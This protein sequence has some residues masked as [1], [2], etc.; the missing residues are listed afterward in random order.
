[1]SATYERKSR[2]GLRAK[3]N[4]LPKKP[5]IYFI[6]N[7]DNAV[8]YIGKARSLRERV[9]S[10]LAPT[11]DPKVHSI[12]T[13][14]SDID[15]LLTDS[16][17]EASFLENNFIQQY[18]PKFNIKLKDDKAFPFLKVTC[19]E[20]FPGIYLT[21]RVEPDGAKYFGPFAPA[22]Q[23]RKNIQL[24]NKYFGVRH[25]LEA[26]P[27]KRKRPCLE[28]DLKFCSAP[29]VG[30]ISKQ[31]YRSQVDSALLFLEGKTEELLGVLKGKMREAAEQQEYERAALLRDLILSIEQLKEKPKLIS[32]KKEDKDIFGFSAE[33][34][35]AY[36]SL[37]RMREGKVIESEII[38]AEM[39]KG[40]PAA[41][42][43]AS[44][45]QE[46]YSGRKDMPDQIILPFH[47]EN[48]E[49]IVKFLSR[50]KSKKIKLLTPVKGENRKLL[51]LA[52]RNAEMCHYEESQEMYPLIELKE[53]LGT[54]SLPHRIEGFDISNTGG[55]E[56]VGSMVV[57][58]AGSPL[59]SEYKKYRIKTVTGPDD[60]SSLKEVLRRRYASLLTQGKEFFPDL[61]LVDGGKGQLNAALQALEEL[62]IK[63][64]AIVSIAKKEEI[65]FIPARKTGIRLDGT[66]P[67]LKLIQ[68]IRDEAHRFAI[69]YH[70]RRRQKKSFGSPLDSIPGI[71][72][73]RKAILLDHFKGMGGIQKAPFEDLAKLVGR[74]AALRLKAALKDKKG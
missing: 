13:E 20:A 16:E 54:E 37:F 61:I 69:S 34:D 66:S 7:K 68:S 2:T 38:A 51:E 45:L 30:Y 48:P 43:L 50:Q 58:E 6:K 73:R 65:I 8:V 23:A 62:G 3:V 67:A 53:A 29:C 35:K 70:R 11:S 18:Q 56:S 72:P 36:I 42:L 5:G 1:M 10:Y 19:Q 28:Y 27:G 9:K 17:K 64:Q 21:R 71:G 40:Q 44:T 33:G 24:V 41:A 49:K 59:K 55:D 15:Y 22:H 60:V 39:K 47:L 57:F 74:K 4:R 46:H 14:T 12:L 25:C 32:V 31:D 63:D 26:I 52:T